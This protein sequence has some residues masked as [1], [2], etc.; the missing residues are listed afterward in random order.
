M[1]VVVILLMETWILD[2]VVVV[3]MT[4]IVKNGGVKL[5]SL[6]FLVVVVWWWWLGWRETD[7]VHSVVAW[8]VSWLCQLRV[9]RSAWTVAPDWW[10]QTRWSVRDD[11]MGS[12]DSGSRDTSSTT[13]RQSRPKR[14]ASSSGASGRC[15]RWCPCSSLIIESLKT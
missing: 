8:C 5:I 11:R 14:P 2:V 15:S 7:L 13:H 9:T 1:V 12:P 4:K 10:A 3:S 6:V